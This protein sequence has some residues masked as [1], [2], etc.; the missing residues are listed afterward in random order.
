MLVGNLLNMLD[1]LTGIVASNLHNLVFVLLGPGHNHRQS[2][3]NLI[4]SLHKVAETNA[5]GIVNRLGPV[6]CAINGWLK[7]SCNINE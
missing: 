5:S 2:V 3:P 4:L 6:P 7:G 1:I